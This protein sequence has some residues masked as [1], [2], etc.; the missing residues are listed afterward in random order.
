MNERDDQ[1]VI[2]SD[3]SA[4]ESVRNPFTETDDAEEELPSLNLSK[5]R[6]A[7]LGVWFGLVMVGLLVLCFLL[8]VGIA[9]LTGN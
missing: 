3:E 7:T 2:E 4:N 5:R 6:A 9:A 8:A 1:E